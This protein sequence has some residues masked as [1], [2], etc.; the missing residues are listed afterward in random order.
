MQA[1]KMVTEL[2]KPPKPGGCIGEP[3]QDDEE[4]WMCLCKGISTLFLLTWRDGAWNHADWIPSLGDLSVPLLAMQAEIEKLGAQALTSNSHAHHHNVMQ[5][6]ETPAM[7]V[8][9]EQNIM[10]EVKQQQQS[11]HAL[12]AVSDLLDCIV[13]QVMEMTRCRDA[14][15]IKT[16]RRI[17]VAPGLHVRRE[18]GDRLDTRICISLEHKDRIACLRFLPGHPENLEDMRMFE[19]IVREQVKIQLIT[20][21]AHSCGILGDR[22]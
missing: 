5:H 6:S 11:W 17:T 16:F 3:Y 20:L 19:S 14:E 10:E 4:R 18:A 8:E 9:Q 2:Q 12:E 13:K 7:S 15:D 1:I 22:V 21:L